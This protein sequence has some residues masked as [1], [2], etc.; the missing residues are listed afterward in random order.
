MTLMPKWLDMEI[1][2]D[3]TAT[4]SKVEIWRGRGREYDEHEAIH[5]TA[6]RQASCAVRTLADGSREITATVWTH[7]PNL[8]RP[9]ASE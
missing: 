4:G 7:V 6:I 9:E 1:S 5:S 2:T 8:E 3:G